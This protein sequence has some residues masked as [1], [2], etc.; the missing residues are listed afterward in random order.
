MGPAATSAPLASYDRSRGLDL[1]HVAGPEYL[2]SE[3]N[4]KIGFR[5]LPKSDIGR[6][7]NEPQAALW[8]VTCGFRVGVA[9]FEPA[10]SSS[11]TAQTFE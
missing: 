1:L 5:S 7:E 4:C 11:R 8:C 10:A 9:G 2:V 6:V 3:V